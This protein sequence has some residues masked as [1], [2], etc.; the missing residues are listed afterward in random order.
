M[1]SQF[2]PL[3]SASIL[4]QRKPGPAF[5]GKVRLLNSVKCEVYKISFTLHASHFKLLLFE[6]GFDLGGNAFAVEAVGGQQL[7]RLL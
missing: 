5:R 7:F 1:R 2:P 6:P 4:N 3:C